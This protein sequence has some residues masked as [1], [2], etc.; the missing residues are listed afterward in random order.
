MVGE[1]LVLRWVVY[2]EKGSAWITSSSVSAKL[3]YL[4]EKENWIVSLNLDQGLN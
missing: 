3:I 2:L 4:V 1:I